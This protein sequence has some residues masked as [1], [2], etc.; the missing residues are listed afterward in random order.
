MSENA[1]NPRLM[2]R[3]EAKAYCRGVDPYDVCP[4]LVFGKKLLWD[5]VALDEALD[6]M[7]HKRTAPAAT[8]PGV[9]ENVEGELER[10]RKRI[11]TGAASGRK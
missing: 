10:A 1:V 11:T 7:R 3:A 2:R 6:A 5:K 8:E 9:N 4:P